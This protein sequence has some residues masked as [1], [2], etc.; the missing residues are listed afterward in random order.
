MTRLTDPEKLLLRKCG[1]EIQ[2]LTAFTSGKNIFN[3]FVQ[4][5]NVSLFLPAET[6]FEKWQTG[7]V[8]HEGWDDFAPWMSD[9]YSTVGANHGSP[10]T[11]KITMLRHWFFEKDMGRV[12][13]DEAGKNFVL[14]GILSPS[15]FLIHS[16][17]DYNTVPF[18]TQEVKGGLY[19]DGVKLDTASITPIQLPSLP[20]VQLLPHYRFNAVKLLADGK[21]VPEDTVIECCKAELHWNI[22]LCLPDALLEYLETHPGRFVSQVSPEISSTVH[23]D[24]LFTFQPGSA[25]TVVCDA[26]FMRDVDTLLKFGLLQHYG[27]TGFD[28][29]EKLIPKLK[30]F[31]LAYCTKEPEMIDLNRPYLLREKPCGRR[32]FMKN[33]CL[34]PA[35]PPRDYI[36]LFGRDGKR[37]LGVAIGYSATRGITAKDSPDRGDFLLSLPVTGKIYP[38]AFYK[39]K[40][41]AQETF[42]LSA[43]RQYIDPSGTKAAAAYGHF[44]EDG[45]IFRSFW[46]TSAEETF[47][48][49]QA[50]AGKTF[51]VIEMSGDI[52]LPSSGKIAS[53]S[54]LSVAVRSSG[55]LTLRVCC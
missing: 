5:N 34:D 15:E 42:H 39:E 35:D 37:E 50:L 47:C 24:L 6:P 2:T 23:L 27:T 22:D 48:F 25:Y 54:S 55:S 36:D 12:L 17:P 43:Y 10:F 53:D 29:H 20:G 26:V 49:P 31:E 4:G 9:G 11:L 46:H 18:F 16:V 30:P 19:A 38:Y 3:R 44:E 1:Q 28:R 8:F 41:K 52:T 45:F 32:H 14:I 40:V 7:E 51:E 33:D 21:E 13:T